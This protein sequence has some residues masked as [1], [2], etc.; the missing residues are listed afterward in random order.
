MGMSPSVSITITTLCLTL[1]QVLGFNPAIQVPRFVVEEFTQTTSN[2]MLGSRVPGLSMKDQMSSTSDLGTYVENLNKI[3]DL[4]GKAK[5]VMVLSGAGMSTAAGIPDFRSAGG[6]Y[7]SSSSMLDKFTYLPDS[8]EVKDAIGRDVKNALT[9]NVL[10]RNPLP[11]HEMRR[12]LILGVAANQWK[13]TLGHLFP[14]ILNQNG[15]LRM[16]A[17]QNVDGIDHKV[18]SDKSK[19]FNPHGLIPTLVSEFIA[20]PLCM[21]PSEPLYEK[22]VEL[23]KE[24]IKDI[25]ADRPPR[26]GK[27]SHLWPGP[28]KS[29]PITLEMFGD[30][31]PA[32]Y[33][34]AVKYEKANKVYS[35][36]PGTVLFDRQLWTNTAAGES[37]NAFNDVRRS[38][39]LLVMGTS[40]SGLTIDMLAQIA[41]DQG[42]PRGVFDMTTAPV[43][44]MDWTEE[45]AFLQQ[46]I[47]M[48]IL[49]ILQKMGWLEQLFDYLPQLCLGSLRTFRQYI[50]DHADSSEIEKKLGKIDAA[51]ELEIDREKYFYGDD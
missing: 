17:S 41:G 29:T 16:L 32:E 5:N 23:V 2:C 9:M 37:Y 24:N 1:N 22:Y 20:E 47:D 36:K 21:E 35:V 12:G 10:A 13:A 50:L 4:L 34:D 33:G 46:P 19:L 26:R 51:I 44:A 40:L 48:S 25:Y 15:K 7:D 6:L 39:L 14:E 31:L 38:D 11:Y 49:D 18:L 45:D 3:V 27:S 43:E 28:E 8:P 42:I 30:L